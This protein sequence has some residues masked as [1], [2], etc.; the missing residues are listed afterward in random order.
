MAK[1]T[2]LPRLLLLDLVLLLA[3]LAIRPLAGWMMAV[4]PTCPVA[5]LGYLCWACGS[6]RCLLSLSRFQLGQA[7]AFH[8]FLCLLA[9]YGLTALLALHL[10]FLPKLRPLHRLCRAMAGHRAIIAW[11]I[12]YGI[13]GIL[14]NL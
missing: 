6:T 11:A 13:F 9:A 5:K 7:F 14:R 4:L 12:A 3:V 8:P 2:A 1:P 10:G